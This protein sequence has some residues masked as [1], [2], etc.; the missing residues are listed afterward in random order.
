MDAWTDRGDLSSVGAFF[1]Q[2]CDN[3]VLL[4]TSQKLTIVTNLEMLQEGMHKVFTVD[5]SGWKYASDIEVKLANAI[6]WSADGSTM[7]MADVRP[8]WMY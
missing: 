4:A 3:F 8:R 5:P 6:C 7:F 2:R 1:L